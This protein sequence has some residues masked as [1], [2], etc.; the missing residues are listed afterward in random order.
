MRHNKKG[1]KLGRNA[2][3]RKAMTKNIVTNLFK[4]GAITTTLQKAKESRPYAERLITRA[5]SGDLSDKRLIIRRLSD[6][7]VAHHLI[8]DI[9]PE[10]S[11][12][13]GGYTRIVKLGPRQGDGAEM[14]VIEV[15]AESVEK[16]KKTAS[17]RKKRAEKPKAKPE[18]STEKVIEEKP[19][20]SQEKEPAKDVDQKLPEKHGKTHKREEIEREHL[21]RGSKAEGARK[22]GKPARAARKP[23][24][25]GMAQ[26]K[27]PPPS[28]QES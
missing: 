22:S 8:N 11:K 26:R 18:T 7:A 15:I 10:L 4:H 17:S 6:R 21:S 1:R 9:A 3:H 5:I 23:I 28:S 27:A 2:S 24:N 19:P 13:K 25:K 20:E 16:Q 14:A 12:R